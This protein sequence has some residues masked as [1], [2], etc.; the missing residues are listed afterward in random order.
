MLKSGE[1]FR[2]TTARP[3]SE[4]LNCCYPRNIH[5]RYLGRPSRYTRCCFTYYKVLIEI[6]RKSR[7]MHN[8]LLCKPLS[9]LV[10]LAV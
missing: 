8:I 2:S 9:S 4:S 6:Q 3:N 10:L 5:E 1:A 7:M